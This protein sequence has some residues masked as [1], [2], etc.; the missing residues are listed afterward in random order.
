MSKRSRA[1]SGTSASSVSAVWDFF[2]PDTNDKAV[3]ICNECQN[4]IRR[5]GTDTKSFGTSS[6]WKHLKSAHNEEYEMGKYKIKKKYQEGNRARAK[7]KKKTAT[8]SGVGVYR[9]TFLIF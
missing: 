9:Q 3:V 5:G 4:K 2:V 8:T 1:G 7:R 6:L